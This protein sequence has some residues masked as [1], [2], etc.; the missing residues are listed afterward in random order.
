MGGLAT[1]D[2]Y[3]GENEPGGPLR[4]VLDEDQGHE[5][6]DHD[7]VGLL[8][9]QG[10]LPVDAHH[11]HHAKIPDDDGQ[12]KVVHGQVVGLEHLPVQTQQRSERWVLEWARHDSGQS[13][14]Y[15]VVKE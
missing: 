2:R 8:E 15:R 10:P 5:G 4:Q 13:A 1:V 12:R 6:A 3:D 11:A 9:P 7:E 14:G